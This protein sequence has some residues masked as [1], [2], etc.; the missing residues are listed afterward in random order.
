MRRPDAHQY[1]E[2]RRYCVYVRTLY[3]TFE[4]YSKDKN[5]TRESG[6]LLLLQPTRVRVALLS[7]Y[8]H[9][10]QVGSVFCRYCV[11]N[12]FSILTIFKEK[13]GR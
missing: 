13:L 4:D 1:R 9:P 8:R 12:M 6:L 2:W 3:G 5:L 10:S 11:Q 7:Q